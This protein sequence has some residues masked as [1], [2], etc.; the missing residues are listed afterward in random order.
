M[1]R[2]IWESGSALDVSHELSSCVENVMRASDRPSQIYK[3]LAS[4]RC[5]PKGGEKTDLH[6]LYR[7]CASFFDMRPSTNLL[8]LL[9]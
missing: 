8:H 6:L 1:S 5:A 4:A 2:A 7:A 3:E 9:S